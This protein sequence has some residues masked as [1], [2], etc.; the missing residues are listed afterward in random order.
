MSDRR[1]KQPRENPI[2]KVAREAVAA[3]RSTFPSAGPPGDEW[4]DAEF[5]IASAAV[6]DYTATLSQ[7]RLDREFIEAD[8]FRFV[9]AK[10]AIQIMRRVLLK[11]MKKA[12]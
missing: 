10:D 7:D 3:F 6:R 4:N 9:D 1:K 8:F 12:S 11:V 5:S 2:D